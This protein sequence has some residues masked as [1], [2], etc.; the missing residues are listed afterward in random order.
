MN[1]NKGV[2]SPYF[3]FRGKTTPDHDKIKKK[4]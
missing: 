3:H 2:F 1:K 4:G